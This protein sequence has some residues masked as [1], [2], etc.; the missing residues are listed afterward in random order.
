MIERS[1][2]EENFVRKLPTKR[3]SSSKRTAVTDESPL[4]T[5]Y[6]IQPGGQVFGDQT[7]HSFAYSDKGD[8]LRCYTKS[9]RRR[10]RSEGKLTWITSALTIVGFIVQFIGL[11]NMHPS[12]SVFQIGCV[13]L[14]SIIRA[15]I[16]TGR[17]DESKKKA[18]ILVSGSNGISNQEDDASNDHS[19][20]SGPEQDLTGHELD[21]VAFEMARNQMDSSILG[22]FE[23]IGDD[24]WCLSPWS[25]S[26]TCDTNQRTATVGN[27]NFVFGTLDE[28]LTREQ[29]EVPHSN[30]AG[31]LVWRY[32]AR[33]GQLTSLPASQQWPHSMV[34]GRSAAAAAERAINQAMTLLPSSTL[35]PPTLLTPS[36][37]CNHWGLLLVPFD[38]GINIK[39]SSDPAYQLRRDNMFLSSGKACFHLKLDE[40][41]WCVDPY[42]IE[43]AVALIAW[44]QSQPLSPLQII[45][46]CVPEDN[47]SEIPR[48]YCSF[49]QWDCAGTAFHQLVERRLDFNSISTEYATHHNNFLPTPSATAI[50]K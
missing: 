11:R 35:P 26:N 24:R 22:P 34:K 1:T 37:L 49:Q 21:Y 48:H 16:R 46:A 19:R 28:L 41:S 2:V 44:S 15:S 38:C 5:L 13:L 4:S 36:G 8:P 31:N 30:N 20:L 17:F 47:R 14:M 23:R 12:V 43:A 29:I 7:F 50:L 32:K 18:N 6:W 39:A 33:L 40:P 9:S 3:G 42:E 45:C 10:E 25:T 27:S